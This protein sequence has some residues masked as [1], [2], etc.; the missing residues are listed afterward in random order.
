MELNPFLDTN[1]F[2]FSFEYPHSN[3]RK[4]I[5]QLNA[6]KIDAIVCEKVVREVIKYF[7]KYYG[8]ELIRLFRRYILG[9][10]IVIANEKVK[11]E[12][13]KWRGK[14]K[15]K[16]LEQLSTVKKYGLKYLVS[17]DRDFE[18]FEEYTTPKE[19]VAVLGL[20]PYETEF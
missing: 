9:S 17:Y 11:D 10:C 14:I 18:D 1:V 13:K 15:E 3:S 20:K 5:E 16:D 6:G 19:F 12:M 7:Q 8:I 4:I 2:I